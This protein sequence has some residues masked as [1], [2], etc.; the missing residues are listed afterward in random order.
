[1]R[2][3]RVMWLYLH[4]RVL[5]RAREAAEHLCCRP[6]LLFVW[7]LECQTGEELLLAAGFPRG[8]ECDTDL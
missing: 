2:R 6:L 7:E 3:V 1:M 4:W 8:G 5:V